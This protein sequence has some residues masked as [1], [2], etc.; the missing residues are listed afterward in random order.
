MDHLSRLLSP[1]CDGPPALAWSA[2]ASLAALAVVLVGPAPW[3]AMVFIVTAVLGGWRADQWRRHKDTRRTVYTSRKPVISLA[4]LDRLQQKV[5]A[6]LFLGHGF[7]IVTRHVAAWYRLR[8]LDDA[9]QATFLAAVEP[10]EAY[11]PILHG[12]KEQTGHLIVTGITGSGKTVFATSFA[13]QR[14][15]KGHIVCVVDPK[16]TPEL[17]GALR[18]V[19]RRENRPFVLFDPSRPEASARFNLLGQF[20]RPTELPSRILTGQSPNDFVQIGWCFLSRLLCAMQRAGQPIH[21]REVKRRMMAGPEAGTADLVDTCLHDWLHGHALDPAM[22]DAMGVVMTPRTAQSASAGSVSAQKHRQ[23]LIQ[24][25]RQHA[26]RLGR[27]DV[28]DALL[29]TYGHDPVHFSKVTLAVQPILEKLTA[30][31]LG[32]IF[33]APDD[34]LDRWDMPRALAEKAVLYLRTDS[35]SDAEVGSALATMFVANV[36]AAA[37]ERYRDA[38]LHGDWGLPVALVIDEAVEAMSIPLLQLMNK[39]RQARFDCCLFTQDIAD[40]EHKL[41]SKALRDMVLGNSNT[42]VSFRVTS[43]TTQEYVINRLG[44]VDIESETLGISIHMK[45]QED[46][47]RADYSAQRSHQR[48]QREVP[49]LSP[50]MLAQLP[51][52]HFV[53]VTP[54]GAGF[55]GVAA[56]LTLND[57][58]V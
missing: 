55:F 36:V 12:L 3:L 42:L 48:T 43:A 52:L 31:S 27:D 21:L 58:Q 40:F 2:V 26:D 38:T 37:G 17:E 56:I 7:R 9:R 18:E 25:Y 45:H 54:Q 51:D 41:G 8:S 15:Q 16:G 50:P 20:H 4:Q 49:V 14:V 28:I 22:V 10:S 47:L 11:Q 44:C 34:T 1:P 19:A 32:D 46:A 39:G 5:P 29:A 35:L 57:S 6:H 24:Y 13:V 33:S 30:A 53:M 23:G